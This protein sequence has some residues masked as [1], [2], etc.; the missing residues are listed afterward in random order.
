MARSYMSFV[1][2]TGLMFLFIFIF[3]LTGMQLFG[4]YWKD[5]PEGLPDNHYDKFGYGLFTVF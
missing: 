2:I 4:G 5:D 3:T 1:Y